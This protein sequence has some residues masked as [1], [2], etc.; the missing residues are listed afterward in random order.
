[1]L[2]LLKGFVGFAVTTLACTSSAEPAHST[3]LLH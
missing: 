1:M 2:L 3:S